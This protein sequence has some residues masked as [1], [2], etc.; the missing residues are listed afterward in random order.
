MI[1]KSIECHNICLLSE[2]TEIIKLCK[3]AKQKMPYSIL[4]PLTNCTP[5]NYND[6]SEFLNLPKKT[7]KRNCRFNKS[8]KPIYKEKIL[9]LML[10]YNK[11]IEV[12]GN[13]N[14]FDDWLIAKNIALG[15]VLPKDLFKNSFGLELLRNEI[16]RIEYGILA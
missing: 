16:G 13:K 4:A 6:W 11:G 8:L 10:I 9:A 7:L 14:T 2:T 5:F 15:G 3:N 1:D 12:W